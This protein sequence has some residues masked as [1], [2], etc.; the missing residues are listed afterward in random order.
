VEELLEIPL[1]HLAAALLVTFAAA[2]V[3]GVIGLGFAIFSVPILSLIDPR[4]APV[5]QLLLSVALT[6][7]MAYR[8]RHAI[9]WRTLV[10]VL[11]GRIPGAILGAWLLTITTPQ[12]LD[13]IIGGSV[14][15]GVLVFS[16]KI[17]VRRNRFSEVV[18]GIGSGAAGT[19]SSI[20]G[21]SLA[22]L[23]RDE[24]GETI[25]ANLAAIFALGL[26][27]SI[28][29]RVWAGKIHRV[30]LLVAAAMLPALFAGLVL[31]G[32]FMG[33]IEGKALRISVL[34]VSAIA[35]VALLLRALL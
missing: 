3:Q 18:A 26:I 20:G 19:I 6:F 27:A 30:E 24:K 34:A 15:L 2:F 16:T 13:L 29:A 11:I 35:A 14:L 12:I 7:S 33:K 22:L 10:W 25:R 17:R 5:P 4:M 8:E 23:Y 32:R 1:L 21:P 28:S 31:S 9:Q